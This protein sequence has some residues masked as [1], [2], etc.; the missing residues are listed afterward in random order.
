[1]KNKMFLT[2]Y[3]DTIEWRKSTSHVEWNFIASGGELTDARFNGY[4]RVHQ[5]ITQITNLSVYM[6]QNSVGVEGVCKFTATGKFAN[7]R[8]VLTGLTDDFN[9]VEMKLVHPNPHKH[10]G[11]TFMA[12]TGRVICLTFTEF[13]Q[14]RQENKDESMEL[15]RTH[16]LTANG[17]VP[18]AWQALPEAGVRVYRFDQLK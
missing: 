2:H 6:H 16:L 5:R 7:D 3:A 10:I 14:L 13:E 8:V 1:M 18:I 4:I 17:I 9:I 11:I 12:A 15:G